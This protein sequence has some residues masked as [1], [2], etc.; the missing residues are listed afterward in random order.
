MQRD[1]GLFKCKINLTHDL[2]MYSNISYSFVLH[3]TRAAL[4]SAKYRLG[5]H[6]AASWGSVSRSEKSA[7]HPLR[8]TWADRQP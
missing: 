3:I 4:K 8:H 2:D 1:S 6:H 7:I 5:I